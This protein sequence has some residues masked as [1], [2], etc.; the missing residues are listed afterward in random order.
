MG[1]AD[2]P[3]PT[4][5]ER[6]DWTQ[7]MFGYD[8]GWGRKPEFAHSSSDPARAFPWHRLGTQ[9]YIAFSAALAGKEALLRRAIAACPPIF[10]VFSKEGAVSGLAARAGD[11][12]PWDIHEQLLREWGQGF[13]P[14]MLYGAGW[15]AASRADGGVA[16]A[17]AWCRR[18]GGPDAQSVWDGWGYRASVYL[19]RD[20]AETVAAALAPSPSAAAWTGAGRGLWFAVHGQGR[21][22]PPILAAASP[23]HRHLL[24]AGVG[25]AATMTSLESLSLWDGA[26]LALADYGEA[27]AVGSARALAI[28]RAAQAEWAAA[29]LKAGGGPGQALGALAAPG[30]G[31]EGFLAALAD[32]G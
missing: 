28:R 13:L 3:P 30:V 25:F 22:L 8:G 10:E 18:A 24:A 29:C 26:R 19:W 20:K 23:S 11:G 2:L 12:I 31:H 21:R 1:L 6:V 4:Q 16:L 15:W 27:F 5:E 17:T 14:V 7:R 32:M 9:M